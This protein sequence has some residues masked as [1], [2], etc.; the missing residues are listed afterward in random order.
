MSENTID[1]LVIK[2]EGQD[3]SAGSTL[4]NIINK[5][6]A[7]SRNTSS[8]SRRVTNFTKRLGALK[9]VINSIRPGNINQ[10]FGAANS[11]TQQLNDNLNN[12]KD[13]ANDLNGTVERVADTAGTSA[14]KLSDKT[15]NVKDKIEQSSKSVKSFGTQV[16]AAFSETI[17]GR[18]AGKVKQIFSSLGRIALYRFM[19]TIIKQVTEAFGTG[20]N[21]LYQY[22]LTFQ[23]SFSQ[24][25]DRAASA[26]L[27]FKNSIGAAIA[28]LIEFL[29]PYLDKAVD[30]LMEINNTIAEVIAGL[31]GKSTFSK[32]VRVTTQYAEAANKA[33]K[34][35][36]KVKNQVEDLKRSF[37]GLD[38]IT[39]I[40]DK[41]SDSMPDMSSSDS[42]VSSTP[43]YSS[44]FVETPVN[45]EKVEKVRDIFKDIWKLAGL[46]AG[47]IA[48]WNFGKALSS[49]GKLGGL[50]GLAAVAGAIM[51]VTGAILEFQGLSDILKNGID[52]ENTLKT[53]LGGALIVAGG[54]LIGLAFGNAFLGAALG[55][56]LA[57]F[58]MVVV[59]I[60]DALK[61]GINEKSALL[62]AAGSTLVGAGIGF[63]IGGPVGALVGALIGLAVGALMDLGIWVYQNWEK[64]CAWCE[65]AIT[66]IG[67]FFKGIWDWI[68]GIW[69]AGVTWFDTNI[70]QPIVGF[71]TGLWEGVSKAA[72]DC[73]NAIV[74]FFSPAI[75]WFSQLFGSIFQTIKD[76]FHNIGVIASGCWEIIKK[77]WGVVT[78]F[79]SNIWNGIKNTAVAAWEGVK[80]VFTT[81]SDWIYRVVIAPV[82]DFFKGL[83]EGFVEKAK[84]AWEGVK[85]VFSAVAGFF[86]R[87]FSEAWEKVVKVF[88]IAGEI[89]VDIKDAIVAAFK[90]VVNGIINGINHVIA[91]PFN[92]INGALSWI[93]DIEIGGWKP[94]SGIV[95]IHVPQI[96]LLA[97]GGIVDS[98]TAFIAGE[99]GPEV[100]AQMGNRTGVMNTDQM[101][102]SVVRG[103]TAANEEQNKLLREQNNLLRQLL[104]KD[105]TI[106][107]S[108][109]TSAMSR[110]NKRDGKVTVPVGI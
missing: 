64:V 59:G 79:F 38:E 26:M 28:P 6:G 31:T 42:A 78:E 8:A 44:M 82:S 77:V 84:Q 15:A 50:K 36:S 41:L 83:W 32:A 49:L 73:W 24:S 51:A 12:V 105:S 23:G 39:V 89:F 86:G 71:F 57:G 48:G 100:V 33:G 63:L 92:A 43:D 52:W 96:P 94:F 108:T 103:V 10:S 74:D 102:E 75:N 22:S 17:I 61:E 4:D 91:I 47:A 35:T 27:S 13:T 76:I 93:R 68:C 16:K 66:D 7:I 53:F 99:A 40:G 29:V 25:M 104:S 20:I 90:W 11:S 45:M 5:L 46:I 34:S 2:V 70:I 37:A 109:I 98:G 69:E 67:N 9:S 54:A 56:I 21:N 81:I 85:Q 62:I 58:P 1:T 95:E 110:Q 72:S 106:N 87:I 88:S 97:N 80:S 30:K 3:E 55:A 14:D 60:I 101:E 107:V 18:F 19:R 65:Q